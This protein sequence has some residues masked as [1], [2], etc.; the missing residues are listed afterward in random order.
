MGSALGDFSL[1]DHKD[2]VR[3]PGIYQ[4]VRDHDDRLCALES[5]DP[6]QNDLLALHINIAGRLIKNIDRT[7]VQKG[8]RQ[9]NSLSLAA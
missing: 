7:V 5:P 2:P 9:S 6:V 4:A 3:V 8:P 1:V